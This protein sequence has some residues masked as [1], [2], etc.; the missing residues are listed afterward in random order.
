MSAYYPGDDYIDWIGISVYGSLQP[1]EER[2]FTQNFDAIYPEFSAISTEKPLAILE[3]GV[4]EGS[5]TGDKAAWIQDALESIKNGRYPRIKA[6]SWW[7]ES[8]GRMA[9]FQILD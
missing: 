8:W 4:T 7:H 9:P 2:T 6:I 3:F 5:A 1:G